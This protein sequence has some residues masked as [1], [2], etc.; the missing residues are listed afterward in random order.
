[1][2]DSTLFEENIVNIAEANGEL[3][4]LLEKENKIYKKNKSNQ[5]VRLPNAVASWDNSFSLF[6][7]ND[8][9]YNTYAAGFLKIDSTGQIVD[10]VLDEIFFE[11]GYI[12]IDS[13]GN[14]YVID[15]VAGF[16]IEKNNKFNYLNPNGPYTQSAF[17]L[18]FIDDQIYVMPGG[19]ASNMSRLKN[20]S[21][22]FTYSYE[23]AWT[24]FDQSNWEL[25]VWDLSDVAYHKNRNE[26]YFASFYFGVMMK[27]SEG[28][29]H[30]YTNNS[31]INTADEPFI[32][33]LTGS[34]VRVP[35]VETDRDGNVWLSNFLAEQNTQF[36]RINAD[37][38]W[39]SF[40]IPNPEGSQINHLKFDLD[41]NIWAVSRKGLVPDAILA[42]SK[43]GNLKKIFTANDLFS[44][45]RYVEVDKNGDIW[46]GTLE[47]I[48]IIKNE[49]KMTDFSIER[50]IINGRYLLESL[51][52]KSITVDGANRKWI[53]T[54]D[55]VWVFNEDGT[56]EIHHFTRENSPLLSNE[57][58]DIAIHPK[59][60]EAFIATAF[61]VASYEVKVQNQMRYSVQTLSR[62]TPTQFQ[63]G[64]LGWLELMGCLKIA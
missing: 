23:N 44:S 21:P 39:T 17:N 52:I 5:W 64:F 25:P 56:E 31:I 10:E 32:N 11:P 42:I 50:P 14:R 41:N 54:S 33:P 18:E 61:G 55:G 24:T 45:P 19:Y 20:N 43:E 15:F 27:D 38:T 28:K 47:G 53:S 49:N 36:C 48:V 62:F 26:V 46:V 29:H 4:A 6:E 37:G 58:L 30:V 22:Y 59:T 12:F 2:K 3:Y 60:G 34:N 16:F 7:I 9:I 51:E 35:S 1:M 40:K 13:K 63:Q 57:I 8:T